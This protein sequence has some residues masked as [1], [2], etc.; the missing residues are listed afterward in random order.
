MAELHVSRAIADGSSQ[1]IAFSAHPV[2]A[3]FHQLHDTSTSTAEMEAQP[4]AGGRPTRCLQCVF[5]CVRGARYWIAG[6]WEHSRSKPSQQYRFGDEDSCQPTDRPLQP[7][8][9]DITHESSSNLDL[10]SDLDLLSSARRLKDLVDVSVSSSLT[11]VPTWASN[12]SEVALSCDSTACIP[13]ND[14]T[15]SKQIG[16]G[17]FSKVFRGRWSEVDVAI[18]VL[19]RSD[20]PQSREALWREVQALVKLRH[21]RICS[22][23]GIS[24]V[25]GASS[26]DALVLEYL[27]CTL[28]QLLRSMSHAE[29]RGCVRG[30]AFETAVALVHLHAHGFIHRDVK[31][32]NI[33]ITE[34]LNAKLSDF[35]ISKCFTAEPQEHTPGI[36]TLRYMAPEV[37]RGERYDSRCDVYSFG[38]LLWEMIHPGRTAFDGLT[39]VKAAAAAQYGGRP[40]YAGT[41]A[42][43]DGT[44]AA[45]TQT[46]F[47]RLSDQCWA[48]LPHE[49]TSLVNMVEELRQDED[50]RLAVG[51][52]LPGSLLDSPSGSSEWSSSEKLSELYLPYSRTEDEY[53]AKVPTGV[54]SAAEIKDN[55]CAP[56][57]APLQ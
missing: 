50:A 33:L 29:L 6:S 43:D 11:R 14:L 8:A 25:A 46:L 56:A 26:L 53:T 52:T 17:G 57:S 51:A 2:G 23:F 28:Y 22:L 19:D 3:G 47:M 39:S 34:T 37:C 36:G 54:K 55:D 7:R 16:A 31:A 12:A 44:G 9:P 18:K 45:D 32:A 5:Y 1:S 15:I 24:V 30:I 40:S 4:V 35:G 48:P 21:P 20:S 49:R 13:W 27:P 10:L 38:L 41:S 42:D